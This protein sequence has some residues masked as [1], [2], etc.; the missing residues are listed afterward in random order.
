MGWIVL[1]NVAPTPLEARL[2]CFGPTAK[3]SILAR[4]KIANWKAKKLRVTKSGNGKP[5]SFFLTVLSHLLTS[6]TL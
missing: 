6:G 2:A 4:H 1:V 3:G 5:K